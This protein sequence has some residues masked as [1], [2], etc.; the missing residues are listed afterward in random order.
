M[1]GYYVVALEGHGHHQ[2]YGEV[3]LLFLLSMFYLQLT[4]SLDIPVL[5]EACGTF[6]SLFMFRSL[7]FPVDESVWSTIH[8]KEEPDEILLGTFTS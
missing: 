8:R 7:F 3:C 5:P 4:C 2:H 1:R 6:F